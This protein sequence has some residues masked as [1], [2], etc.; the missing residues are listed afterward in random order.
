MILFNFR[1][2]RQMDQSAL[3]E[4]TNHKAIWN[5]PSDTVRT[6]PSYLPDLREDLEPI[7]KICGAS[8]PSKPVSPPPIVIVLPPS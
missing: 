2:I 8:F 3:R 4:L 1:A 6:F 7:L 5:P